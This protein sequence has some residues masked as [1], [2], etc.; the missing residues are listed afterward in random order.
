[1]HLNNKHSPLGILLLLALLSMWLQATPPS[2][3]PIKVIPEKKEGAYKKRL[4]ESAKEQERAIQYYKKKIRQREDKRA[5]EQKDAQKATEPKTAQSKDAPDTAPKASSLERG[6]IENKGA[7]NA[8]TDKKVEDAPSQDAPSKNSAPKD[9]ALKDF[10]PDDKPSLLDGVQSLDVLGKASALDAK[11]LRMALTRDG[12]IYV[13]LLSVGAGKKGKKKRSKRKNK[14]ILKASIASTPG[15]KVGD[16]A[17]IIRALDNRTINE[18]IIAKATVKKI[19]KDVTTLEISQSDNNLSQPYLPTP[20]L[21]ARA[22]DIALFHIDHKKAFII[23]PNAIDYQNAARLIKQS[24]EGIKILPSDLM[25]AVLI[26]HHRYNPNFKYLN[27]ACTTYMAGS[28]FVAM[29]TG[30]YRLDCNSFVTIDVLPFSLVEDKVDVPFFTYLAD[31]DASLKPLFTR[32]YSARYA[33]YYEK[34]IRLGNALPTNWQSKKEIKIRLKKPKHNKPVKEEIKDLKKEGLQ[35]QSE[36]DKDL[37]NMED[38]IGEDV[39]SGKEAKEIVSD[40]DA[41]KID[42][43]KPPKADKASKDANPSSKSEQNGSSSAAKN[44]PLMR[45]K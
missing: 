44:S 31:S 43:S 35:D 34:L 42:E 23:A 33:S 32:P 20:R 7:E 22:G 37:A 45:D 5:E 28:I 2:P 14:G 13:K 18:I 12:V 24:Y 29:D 30:L 26:E 17:V 9:N 16:S 8:E 6:I 10:L 11:R 3:H 15:L 41:S 19:A 27:L 38:D 36:L 40:K 1:M 39:S 25:L 21:E 4:Q